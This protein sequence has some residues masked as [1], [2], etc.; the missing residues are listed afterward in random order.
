MKVLATSIAFSEGE[1]GP[2]FLRSI[3]SVGSDQIILQFHIRHYISREA[4]VSLVPIPLPESCIV[5]R[6]REATLSQKIYI[7]QPPAPG[8]ER[9]NLSAPRCFV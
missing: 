2:K 1:Q 3:V 5:Q 7:E 4:D 8:E 9:S 6:V